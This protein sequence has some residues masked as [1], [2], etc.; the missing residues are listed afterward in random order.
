VGKNWEDDSGLFGRLDS[1]G[2]FIPGPVMMLL[3][4]ARDYPEKPH[5]LLLDEMDQSK[6]MDYL[7]IL[8]DGI[9]GSHETL[10]TREDFG[11]DVGAY[12]EFGNII[13]P[14]NVY[15]IGTLNKANGSYP[16]EPRVIDCGNVIEMPIVE[17]G[18][19][20]NYGSVTNET[21]WDNSQFKIKNKV[22]GLPEILEKLMYRLS[23]LQEILKKYHYPL[24]YRGKNEILTYGINSGAEG[25]FTE[26]E[27]IDFAILQRILP[28]LDDSS[29]QMA[30][31]LK[32]LGLFLLEPDLKDHLLK[33]E[34]GET[35]EKLYQKLLDQGVVPCHR[36]GQ[37]LLKRLKQ[38]E[39]A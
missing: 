38:I 19:F 15:V 35:F 26:N 23:E 2:H 21:E 6:V 17:I 39:S 33:E 34:S 5:F 8:L 27:V 4:N 12:R 36:S 3:K 24:G 10:R 25:L 28:A 20:P 31:L 30:L 9:N 11:G 1:R 37:Q 7:R 32:E 29:G 16:L 22:Q 14:D 13:F 18:A